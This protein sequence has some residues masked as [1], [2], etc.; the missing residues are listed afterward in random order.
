MTDPGALMEADAHRCQGVLVV[1]DDDAIRM[2]VSQALRE[3]G[4]EVATASNG[5]QALDWLHQCHRPP[6]V[7]LLDLMMPVMD[8]LA[9]RE[10]QLRDPVLAGVPVVVLTADGRA[11]QRPAIRDVTRRLAKPIRL[12]ALLDVIASYCGPGPRT[13]TE[14]SASR[15]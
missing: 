3:E 14:Q 2:A 5:R 1:D 12:G 13:L 11:A 6:C 7:I 4:Y 15:C 8:G 9:F 10:E